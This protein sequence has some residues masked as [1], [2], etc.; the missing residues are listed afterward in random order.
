[1]LQINVEGGGGLHYQQKQGG[2]GGF[3]SGT[4][5]G[6]RLT[7]R[8]EAGESQLRNQGARN[9]PFCSTRIAIVSGIYI[10][11]YLAC[12]FYERVWH[13]R[14]VV[15]AIRNLTYEFFSPHA[16]YKATADQSGHLA[17]FS[18]VLELRNWCTPKVVFYLLR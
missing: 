10:Y 18:G 3:S 15:P 9:G 13:C 17:F 8:M 7:N 6:Y 2:D 14:P 1:M 5:P 12:C 4:R 16:L 11:I